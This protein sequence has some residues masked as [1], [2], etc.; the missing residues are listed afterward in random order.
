MGADDSDDSI[1]VAQP[2]V[3]ARSP[4]RLTRAEMDDRDDG[5]AGVVAGSWGDRI[6]TGFGDTSAAGSTVVAV[7]EA[8]SGALVS[9]SGSP[10]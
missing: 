5:R 3:H 8:R 7:V 10:R 2:L 6:Q 4:L 9:R 1:V